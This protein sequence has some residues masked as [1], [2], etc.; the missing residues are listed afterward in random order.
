MEKFIKDLARE[1]GEIIL[2]KFGK[3][4]V[5]YIKTDPTDMVT[6]ADLAANKFINDAIKKKFPTHGIISEEA[7][8]FQTHA[9]YVWYVDPLDGTRNFT[10][11]TP[12]FSSMVG[13]AYKGRMEL[14]AI[15]DPVLND[16][17]FAARGKGA[18]WNEHK[19]HCSQ[20]KKLEHSYG[21]TGAR[22]TVFRVKLMTAF[23]EKAKREPFWLN[24]FG[25]AGTTSTYVA[26]GRRDWYC[27]G[28]GLSWDYAAA[29]LILQESGCKVTTYS[30]KPWQVGDREMVAANPALHKKLM[31]IIKKAGI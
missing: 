26:S 18:F 21:C 3:I 25:S 13:L 7:A 11:H 28:E 12:L 30:G 15:F 6:E 20:T 8:E 16:L 29:G 5:K 27:G 2:E 14:A 10:T 23:L 22:L 9:D 24:M 19:I 17:F 31:E 4:S 1:A